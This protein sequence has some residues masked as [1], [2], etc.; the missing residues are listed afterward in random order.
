MQ[1]SVK[2]N[3]ANHLEAHTAYSR[4]YKRLARTFATQVEALLR[5]RTGGRSRVIVEHVTVEKGGQAIVGA[6]ERG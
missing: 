1:V 6:I 5:H 4:S 2:M 3:D